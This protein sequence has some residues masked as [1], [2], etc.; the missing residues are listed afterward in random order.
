RTET[1]AANIM[2]AVFIGNPFSES[3]HTPFIVRIIHRTRHS[4]ITVNRKS[5]TP[6]P[7]DGTN[8]D[9]I[10]LIGRDHVPDHR[11]SDQ[12]QASRIDSLCSFPSFFGYPVQVSQTISGYR[13]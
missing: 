4:G 11:L 8:I 7:L 10:T 1:I 3:H 6:R 13:I 2:L 12:H 5:R 9:D